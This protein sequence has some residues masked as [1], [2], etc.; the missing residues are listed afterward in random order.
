MPSAIGVMKLKLVHDVFA[1]TDHPFPQKS[2]GTAPTFVDAES[3]PAGHYTSA[4][5]NST[6]IA[7]RVLTDATPL[8]PRLLLS[9]VSPLRSAF[10]Q[11]QQSFFF[12]NRF[13]ERGQEVSQDLLFRSARLFY[14]VG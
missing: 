1:H 5:L 14:E 4:N 12:L 10:F 7:Y 8:A 3:A 11:V 9:H 13:L 6:H 2:S